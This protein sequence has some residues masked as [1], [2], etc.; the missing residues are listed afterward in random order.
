M[1]NGYVANG[2]AAGLE[3]NILLRLIHS[4][5]AVRLPLVQIVVR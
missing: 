4:M 1:I 5:R 3:K 2:A